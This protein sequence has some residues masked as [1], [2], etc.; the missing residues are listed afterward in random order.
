[1]D[2]NKVVL[3]NLLFTSCAPCV[4]EI[5]MLNQLNQEYVD[6][7]FRLIS[8]ATDDKETLY[9]FLKGTPIDDDTFKEQP[10]IKAKR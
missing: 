3:I 4:A 5:P 6:K 10:V 8:F 2:L 7:D 1:M 9:K